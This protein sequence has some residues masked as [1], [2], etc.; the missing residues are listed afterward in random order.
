MKI[1]IRWFIT[2]VALFVAV[3][4]V[5][6]ISVGG[7]SA[8]LIYALMAI[9]LGLVNTFIRP[10]LKLLS[11]GFIAATLGLFMLVINAVTLWLASWIAQQLG[12]NFIVDGFFAAFLGSL[13]VSFVSWLLN[14]FVKDE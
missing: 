14:M 12:I 7:G 9:V 8:W 5:P 13:I 4:L 1:F 10:L 3:W 2:V 6:G 11:C